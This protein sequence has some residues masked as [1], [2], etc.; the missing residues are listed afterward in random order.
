MSVPVGYDPSARIKSYAGKRDGFVANAFEDQLRRHVDVL[1]SMSFIPRP[2][3]SR[4]R[5]GCDDFRNIA[6]RI[7]AECFRPL[8]EM[9]V[10]LLGTRPAFVAAACQHLGGSTVHRS[11]IT[12]LAWDWPALLLC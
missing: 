4:L 1:M 11:H 6:V 7:S 2:R 3:R 12:Q 5:A 8:K 9:K 10:Q